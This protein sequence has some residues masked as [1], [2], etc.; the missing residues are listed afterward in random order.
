[1]GAIDY[2]CN[3]FT[4]D[5]LPLWDAAI[6]DQG[7]SIKI[8]RDGDDGFA[9]PDA[10]LRRMDAAGIDTLVL[11]AA[12]VP[13]GAEA[14][15]Y[16]RYATRP[17]VVA[18][19]ATTYPGRF[20]GLAGI[21]PSQ[22]QAG[23][24]R[25]A[26][27]LAQPGFVGLQLHTHSWDRAFDHRD[28]YPFYTLAADCGVPVVMQAGASGGPLPSEC[29]RPTGID[30]PAI[31]FSGVSFV[32]SHTGWPWTDE[33]LAMV[34][35]HPNVFLGTAA[36][37]P[38]H[39]PDALRAFIAHRGVGKVLFGTSFPVVGHRHALARLDDLNLDPEARRALLETTA[40]RLFTRL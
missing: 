38:H 7:L 3:A 35:K 12:E 15:A 22:G 40:R 31:Y 21:D 25:A 33:A 28:L 36:W 20:A 29:G 10:M 27:L 14:F 4:P 1:M 32:L 19:L 5:S 23:V 30:R 17:E 24:S 9:E 11:P 26:E 18:K 39:W 16:E 8:Q 13:E 6:A 37:P 2:W 34:Q